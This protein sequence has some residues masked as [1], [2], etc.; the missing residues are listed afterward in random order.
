MK[1][2]NRAHREEN[3]V[4]WVSGRN[5]CLGWV[6]RNNNNN[7]ATGSSPVGGLYYIGPDKGKGILELKHMFCAVKFL[8]G[9]VDAIRQQ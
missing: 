5:W 4:R 8:G 6:G 2:Y 7:I 9:S 1:M 3:P